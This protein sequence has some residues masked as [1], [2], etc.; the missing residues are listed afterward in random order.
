MYK[1]TL[2]AYDQSVGRVANS[3]VNKA[4]TCKA[5]NTTTFSQHLYQTINILISN[6]QSSL[7]I[8]QCS[9]SIINLKT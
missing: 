4:T 6:L 8:S 2:L 3:D 1:G 7:Q 9:I 5:K